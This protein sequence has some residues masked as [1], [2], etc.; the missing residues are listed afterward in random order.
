ML[1]SAFSTPPG[2]EI[3]RPSAAT[4]RA[5][6]PLREYT[7]PSKWWNAARRRLF[8]K[9]LPGRVTLHPRG[10]VEHVG[11]EYGGWPVP[12]DLLDPDAIAYS[13]GAGGDVSFDHGL[14][15]RTGCEVHSF[16]P[17]AAAAR[18]AAENERAGFTFHKVAVWTY[19][20]ELTMYGAANP[21]HMALSAVNLQH[22]AR[23]AR[24][25]CT[26]IEIVRERLGHGEITLLKL[27]VD[28]GEYELLPSFDLERWRTRVLIVN[29]QHSRSVRS[30]VRAVARLQREGFVAVARRGTGITFVH[31][32]RS[33]TPPAGSEAPRIRR[34]HL[35]DRAASPAR[36]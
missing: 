6:L 15:E 28:G 4:V 18:H 2:R 3:P 29:F 35:P 10:D 23:T 36:P 25:P 27:T 8:E 33:L 11:S 21:G 26:T 22:T 14:I 20:G 30:A 16:D 32:R 24:V 9:V 5:R 17:T 7:R 34:Q 13:V 12:L 19:A 1:P 31:V